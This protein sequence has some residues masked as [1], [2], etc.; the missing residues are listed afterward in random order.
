MALAVVFF[1]SACSDHGSGHALVGT[2]NRLQTP[3]TF[4]S[5]HVLLKPPKSA[6]HPRIPAPRVLIP[7]AVLIG[8]P[9]VPHVVFAQVTITDLGVVTAT[10]I[11]PTFDNTPEWVVIYRNAKVMPIGG[12]IVVGANG[13]AH[14]VPQ[15]ASSGT[16]ISLISA[17]S[18]ST[19]DVK[20]CP[21]GS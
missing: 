20:T 16:I 5:G 1:L 15:P 12:P 8:P 9:P 21:W 10:G 7:P 19:L 14:A 3:Q 18:G 17:S 6:Q 2:V 4:C 13:Q 11:H